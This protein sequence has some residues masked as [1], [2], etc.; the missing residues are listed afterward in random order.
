MSKPAKRLL[1]GYR[2]GKECGGKWFPFAGY[3]YWDGW[4][5]F[6]RKPVNLK[7]RTFTTHATGKKGFAVGPLMVWH[8]RFKD[9]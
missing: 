6:L 7:F 4:H 3:G 8:S 9:D 1:F 2:I 5:S